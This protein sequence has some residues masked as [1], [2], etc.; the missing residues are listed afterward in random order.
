MRERGLDP[1]PWLKAVRELYEPLMADVVEETYR[2]LG[3]EDTG[4]LIEIFNELLDLDIAIRGTYTADE[5]Q[6]GLLYLRLWES[7]KEIVWLQLLFLTGNYLPLHRTCGTYGRPCARRST[8]TPAFQALGQNS[9]F[10][11]FKRLKGK[12]RKR[13]NGGS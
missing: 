9:S 3:P 11:S 13:I 1:E 4:H 8:L 12:S 6:Q 2:C 5:L 10:S 7:L